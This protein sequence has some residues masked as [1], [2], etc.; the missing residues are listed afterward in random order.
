MPHSMSRAHRLPPPVTVSIAFVHGMLTGL[1]LRG[2]PVEP[3][4]VR[5]G[6]A[7]ALLAQ[8][9]A[10]VTGDQY[11]A[12]FRALIE[13]FGDEGL[14]LFS[15]T[16]RRGTLALMTRSALGSATVEAALHRICRSLDLLQDD[17]RCALV[18]EGGATGLAI[19]VPA[20]FYPERA[21]VHEML[22][23]VL[24][25][26]ATWLH[27]GR[28]KALRFDLAMPRPPHAAEYEKL[29]PGAVHF[30]QPRTAV[31]FDS[32][33]LAQPLRRDEAA[34]R[35]FLAQTPDIVVTPPRGG[36]A[37]S[38]RVRSCLQQARPRW[39]ELPAVAAELHLSV[40]TL[41]RHLTAEGSSFQAVK[42]QLR[43]DLAVVRLITSDVPLAVLAGELGFSDS[44]TFQR[45]FKGWTGSAPGVYRRAAAAASPPQ[46]EAPVLPG[47]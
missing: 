30:G 33:A 41:Q 20:S 27:G 3:W 38:A 19:E 16:L 47:A 45:A 42:D 31:W 43:R 8:P 46:E 35:E 7:P 17:V 1:R 11:V 39:L 2:E 40:S 32:A 12:L 28:L 9:A 15:R 44:A 4:L 18:R 24:M 34:W 22:L 14:G 21:F 5:A 23:R 6:I 26:V 13:N 25:R 29:F 10:R 36:N 37:A